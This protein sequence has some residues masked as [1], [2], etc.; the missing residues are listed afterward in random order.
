MAEI[1]DLVE[2]Q[3]AE[4]S[5]MEVILVSVDGG[6]PGKDSLAKFLHPLGVNFK[7]YY[8]DVK[9]NE[10][11]DSLYPDWGGVYPVNLFYDETSKKSEAPPKMFGMFEPFE[12]EMLINQS[13]KHDLI[14]SKK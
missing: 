5:P 2:L 6:D 13:E 8:S 7:T 1:P 10:I 9:G 12:I 4:D 14:D 3:N 11:L